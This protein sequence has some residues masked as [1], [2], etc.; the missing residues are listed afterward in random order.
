MLFEVSNIVTLVF[1]IVLCISILFASNRI[2]YAIMGFGERINFPNSK[3]NCKFAILIP[4]RN[5]SKVIDDLFHALAG[6][7]YP[8]EKFD[9][10]V[11]VK[12]KTDKTVEIAQNYGFNVYVDEQQKCKGDALDYAIKDIYAKNLQYDA[13]LIFDADNIPT[14]DFLAEMNKAVCSGYD[15]G[16]GY[17]NS[18]NWNDGWVACSTGLTF[19]IINT[20]SNKGRTKAGTNCIFSGTGYF[21]KK[22]VL[23]KFAGWPFKTLTEDYE[24]SQYA[25]LNNLKTAYV[26]NA[27]FFDEQPTTLA[28]SIKQRERWVKGFL[29]ANKIYTKKI[30]K[31]IFTDKQN[32][33]AKIEQT[34][35]IIP[36]AMIV[37]DVILYA[38]FQIGFFVTAKIV[39]VDSTLFARQFFATL[40]GTY[41]VL[42][43]LTM[44]MFLAEKKRVQ[45]N[46]K[47]ILST[48][49]LNPFYMS[50]YIPIAIKAI[51]SKNIGWDKIEHTRTKSQIEAEK[52]KE[53]EDENDKARETNKNI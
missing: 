50:L 34:L 24:I 6:Q 22:S 48:L 29:S 36:I 37:A 32:K 40:E 16:I 2:V 13:F 28:V 4:A 52:I 46:S 42:V 26:E 8:K 20:L 39:S 45:I 3:K 30:A 51:F 44:I 1:K 11:I 53:E 25:T 10:F 35:G 47:T 43:A 14:K 31:A 49:L 19:S 15:I 18:K 38:L 12:Q 17:R 27:E 5:E 23:D 41:L 33:F 7:K 21:I 9:V